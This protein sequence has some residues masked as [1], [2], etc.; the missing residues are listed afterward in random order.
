MSANA[1]AQFVVFLLLLLALSKPL[2]EYMGRVFERERTF[3][4]PVMRPLERGLYH[5]AGISPEDHMSWRAYAGSL[6]LFN[7]L[8]LGFLFL[9]LRFQHL[10]PLNP[11][12]FPG[13]P[14]LRAWYTPV[15]FTTTT[16][17]RRPQASRWWSRSPEG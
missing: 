1:L 16:N 3:L 7:A 10:L 12:H 2:G 6:L 17:C 5:L 13:L 8:G 11:Q 14:P 4:D 15:S 9:I